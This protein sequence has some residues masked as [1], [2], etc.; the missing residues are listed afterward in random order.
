MYSKITPEYVILHI[1]IQILTPCYKKGMGTP[2]P[3]PTPSQALL[4]IL[5]PLR[6]CIWY[7]I[8][9]WDIKMVSQKYRAYKRYPYSIISLFVIL[10]ETRSTWLFLVLKTFHYRPIHFKA[11]YSYI[12]T[13]YIFY[14]SSY[15]FINTSK[16][17]HPVDIKNII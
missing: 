13:T 11:V 2:L 16:S 17:S 15:C 9:Y 14:Y 1:K 6:H 7:N 12:H 8:N 3:Q 5:S 10:Y 4:L